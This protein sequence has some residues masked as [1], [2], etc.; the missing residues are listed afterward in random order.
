MLYELRHRWYL[1]QKEDKFF[2]LSQEL[3]V[4]RNNLSELAASAKEAF[5]NPFGTDLF[6]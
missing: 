4:T 6:V 5:P 2:M 3:D 1:V